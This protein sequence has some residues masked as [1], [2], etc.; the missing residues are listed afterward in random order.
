MSDRLDTD[1]DDILES[2]DQAGTQAE[3]RYDTEPEAPA[4]DIPAAPEP[5]SPGTDADGE[6]GDVDPELR[7]LFWKLVLVIKVALLSLSLGALFVI[8]DENPVIGGQ[9]LAFG[10]LF[11]G[12][13]VYRYRQIKTRME[14]G[15]FDTDSQEG[16]DS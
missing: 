9:L 5:P 12:F 13:A 2:E 10:S 16:A 8:F 11:A 1:P 3:N 4:V 15:E 7:T 6:F 14:N